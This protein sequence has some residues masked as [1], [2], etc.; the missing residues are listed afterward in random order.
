MLINEWT[1]ATS[2][3][4]LD[5]ARTH[6][7]FDSDTGLINGTNVWES[8]GSRFT[9]TFAAGKSYLIRLVNVAIDTHF[10]FSIDNHTLT[11]I[12]TD[13]VPIN[14]VTV[15][16]L[17]IGIGRFTDTVSTLRKANL[18]SSTVRYHCYCKSKFKQLLAP[19]CA[20][21]CLQRKQQRR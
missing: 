2:A 4:L 8:G 6:G 15:D 1:H 19:C 20:G 16:V 21:H 5:Y 18:S 14:P 10:K 17:S 12:A 13:L 7:P 11:L 3:S 9:T